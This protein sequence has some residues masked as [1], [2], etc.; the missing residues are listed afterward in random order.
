MAIV[1][2]VALAAP[3]RCTAGSVVAWGYNEYGQTDVPP[4]ATN[5]VAVAGGGTTDGTGHSM[6][7]R[8]DGTVLA[9]GGNYRGECTVP[10]GLTNVLA[11]AAGWA[12]SLSLRADGTVVAWGHN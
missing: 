3:V 7:L 9:W 2:G 4:D 12:H 1:V 10:D 11:I 6:A 8:V 5:V